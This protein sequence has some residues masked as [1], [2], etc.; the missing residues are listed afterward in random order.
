MRT[1]IRNDGVGLNLH[2]QSRCD[3]ARDLDHGGGRADVRK[4]L[5]VHAPDGFPLPRP[6]YRSQTIACAPRRS[7]TPHFGRGP[8]GSSRAQS[9]SGPRDHRRDNFPVV[10]RRGGAGHVHGS[11]PRAP[12]ASIRQSTPTATRS[13]CFAGGRAKFHVA[14][15]PR[16]RPPSAGPSR[17]DQ[18]PLI[19]EINPVAV[20]LRG[21][22][23]RFV[24]R[25]DQRDVFR[26]R[27]AIHWLERDARG[28][29]E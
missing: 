15:T 19:A 5:A 8:D 25:N 16:S 3:E 6:R 27:G 29:G 21:V 1:R 4:E 10:P 24:Q 2:K 11:V 9:A 23:A 22:R 17:L 18:L 14:P 7:R 13:R 20:L 12:R 28:H 26:D